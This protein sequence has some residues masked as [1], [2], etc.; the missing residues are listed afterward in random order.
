MH[1]SQLTVLPRLAVPDAC[2]PIHFVLVLLMQLAHRD[3]VGLLASMFGGLFS[4]AV[5]QR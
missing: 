1:K 3:S 4:G 2:S 5:V